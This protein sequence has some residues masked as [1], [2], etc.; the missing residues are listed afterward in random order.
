MAKLKYELKVKNGTYKDRN[1]QE[2]NSWLKVGS[3]FESDKGL[4]IKLDSVPVN[5]DGWISMFEPRP[6]DEDPFA[7]MVRS[8][9][10]NIPF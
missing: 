10:E 9:V 3:C 2:K 6:K 1:G 8:T 4:S 7:G 5:F